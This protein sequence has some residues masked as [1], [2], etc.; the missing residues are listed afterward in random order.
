MNRLIKF[1]IWVWVAIIF[2]AYLMQF[3]DYV[4]PV[5]RM[6]MGLIAHSPHA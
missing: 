4:P 5:G 1:L 6:I 3:K 2:S